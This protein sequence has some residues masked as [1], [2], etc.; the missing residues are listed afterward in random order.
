MPEAPP[1]VEFAFPGP[2]RD[3]LVA[4]VLSGAK[5]ASSGLR[6]EWEADGEPLPVLGQRQT[7]VDSEGRPVGVIEV[8]GVAV[9]RLGDADRALAED[10]GEGFASVAEWREAHE[11]FWREEVLPGLADPPPL[12]DDTE[13]V[14]ERFRLIER[15][16]G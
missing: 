2:L 3:K 5:N 12:D 11:R 14:V 10:E 6:A 9:L 1:P 13:I 16:D 15:L 4:A 8:T 7:V